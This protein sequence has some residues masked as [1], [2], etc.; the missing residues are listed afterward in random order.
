MARELAQVSWL[1]RPNVLIL[2][3]DTLRADRL[4]CYG[5]T[6][7]TSPNIDALAKD[8]VL[9][10]R[11]ISQAP[12]TLP[13]FASIVTGVLPSTHGAGRGK[14]WDA[15]HLQ[16][17]RPTLATVL[18]GQGYRTASFVSNGWVS[19]E[20]GMTEGI[21][22]RD[23]VSWIESE[24]VTTAARDWLRANQE[25]PFYMFLHLIDPHAPYAPAPQHLAALGLDP[26]PDDQQRVNEIAALRRPLKELRPGDTALLFDL[27]DG[28]VHQSD[29]HVGVIL[30]EL[31][32]LGRLE[33][34]IVVLV[35]D[36]G[37]ELLEHGR[38]GHG[39]TL[40]DEL[41]HVPLIIRA[42][43][44]RW[45]GRVPQQVRTMDVFPTVLD[46]LR[47][48]PPA[49]LEGRSLLPLMQGEREPDGARSA[50]SEFLW[51]GNE[52]KSLRRAD[53]KMVLTPATGDVYWYD[54]ARDPG[55]TKPRRGGK[56]GVGLEVE[57]EHVFGTR[58]DGLMI[59]AFGDA[60]KHDLRLV[61]D[62]DTRFDEVAVEGGEVSERVTL[63]AD[64]RR[65]K[66]RL[67]L[68][69]SSYPPGWVDVDGIRVR[70]RNDAPVRVSGSLDGRPLAPSSLHVGA[71]RRTPGTGPPWTF[72][73]DDPEVAVPPTYRPFRE[74]RVSI[75]VMTRGTLKAEQQRM[76]PETERNL[77]ALGYVE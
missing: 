22:P 34:T 11:A 18:R 66:A 64:G 25:Q 9:F 2:A 36:H 44:A 27:Y 19:F 14:G 75:S 40:H 41:L 43:G 52:Q 16:P 20:A 76:S 72:S 71:K 47:L 33:R 53:A 61:L 54:L 42:P 74:K 30:D 3:I 73:L 17:G 12:W 35:S 13:A 8:S 1:E 50:A 37:E 48:P 28:E 46:L 51:Q 60:R 4:G 32:A 31:R 69:G 23:R 26:H 57:L 7:P 65:L 62:T 45:T 77:R 56:K 21:D 38:F 55:E 10:E 49:G 70:T 39:H 68:D 15:A 6:R 63:S 24:S 67:R 58:L 5:H 29:E 59:S